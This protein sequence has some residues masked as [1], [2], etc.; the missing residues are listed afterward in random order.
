VRDGSETFGR[1]PWSWVRPD[2]DRSGPAIT[3]PTKEGNGEGWHD[4]TGWVVGALE[5]GR[6]NKGYPTAG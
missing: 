5:A 4:G 1:L 2:M 6:V 3:K